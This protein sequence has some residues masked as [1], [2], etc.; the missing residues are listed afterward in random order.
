MSGA[1]SLDKHFKIA[2]FLDIE[3]HANYPVTKKNR[4]QNT[5]LPFQT[6]L[7]QTISLNPC[8]P[9]KRSGRFSG[10]ACKANKRTWKAQRAYIYVE[11]LVIN[12]L[13]LGFHLV[14]RLLLQSISFAHISL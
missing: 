12:P 5:R 9:R 3:N 7:M 4:C 11:L 6:R 14:V 13:K 8:C 2:E 1:G 10:L